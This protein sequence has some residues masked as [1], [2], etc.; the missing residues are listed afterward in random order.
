MSARFFTEVSGQQHWKGLH[1]ALFL[2]PP[3]QILTWLGESVSF[4]IMIPVETLVLECTIH[5]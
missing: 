5:S 4:T 3:L 1:V 2:F